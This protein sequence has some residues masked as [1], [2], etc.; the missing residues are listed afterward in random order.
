MNQK[1]A[2][3]E[4]IPYIQKVLT[5]NKDDFI[6]SLNCYLNSKGVLGGILGGVTTIFGSSFFWTFILATL[7][8]FILKVVLFVIIALLAP[9]LTGIEPFLDGLIDLIDQSLLSLDQKTKAKAVI[10]FLRSQAM[11]PVN[12]NLSGKELSEFRLL[13]DD[14]ENYSPSG[15]GDLFK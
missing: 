2:I 9:Y 6:S 11:P 13:R 8:P 3:D 14:L 1:Q 10:S 4:L 5:D 7:V 15:A 12:V